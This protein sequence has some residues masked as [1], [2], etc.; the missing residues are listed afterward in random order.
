MW[1]Q[2]WEGLLPTGVEQSSWHNSCSAAHLLDQQRRR[3][4]IIKSIST[5]FSLHYLSLIFRIWLSRHLKAFCFLVV[6]LSGFGSVSILCQAASGAASSKSS[7]P[8]I[9]SNGGKNHFKSGAQLQME[10]IESHWTQQLHSCVTKTLMLPNY[11]PWQLLPLRTCFFL[12]MLQL[13]VCEGLA[14][15]CW[16]KKEQEVA[17]VILQRSL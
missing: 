7:C 15:V 13:A 16:R 12:T 9:Y 1:H 5:K 11:F 4:I 17:S 2:P 14:G 10:A 8:A 3:K 6:Q